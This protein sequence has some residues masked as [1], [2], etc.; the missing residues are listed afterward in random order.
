MTI[1]AISVAMSVYDGERFLALAIESVLA[2]TFTDF[3]FL[4][5]NDGSRDASASIIDHYAAQD[6]RIRAIHRENRGLVASL[7]Q[8]LGEAKAPLVARM[9]CDDIC[10]PERFERQ[11][12]FMAAHPEYGVVGTWSA[13]ID[14]EGNPFGLSGIDHPTDHAKFLT[15]IQQ[16]GPLLCHPSVMMRRDLVRSVGGYH[17]A[18]KHCEDYD[19]WLRLASVT[20]LCSIPDRLV[21]YRH[22]SNQVSTKFAYTQQ[23][24]AAVSYFAWCERQAGLPD[25]T[26]LLAELPPMADYDRLFK[27]LDVA[28]A[29][30]DRVTPTMI[31]SEVALKGEGYS[32][33]LDHVREGGRTKGL[34][35]TVARLMRIGEPTKAA[36]LFLTL[37]QN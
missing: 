32:L 17:A 24:G 1:P 13:D 34:W 22:W 27:K 12:E 16:S 29:V 19:L 2:Q 25:P 37:A 18:F 9:D 11:I 20:Q 33:M 4:I 7:N 31:Y 15:S 14:E 28:K 8:M 3:E 35:R 26:E 36:T 5:L 30:R 10:L 23:I 21:R 6:S